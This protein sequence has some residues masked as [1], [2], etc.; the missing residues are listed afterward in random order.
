M[1]EQS[2]LG[3]AIEIEDTLSTEKIWSV[4]LQKI[5]RPQDFLPVTDVITRP[6]D[7]GKGTYREMTTGFNAAN[8]RPEVRV[9][10]NIYALEEVLEVLFVVIN[11]PNEH[12]NAIVTDEKGKRSLTFFLRNATT[13][14]RVNWYVPKAVVHQGI[15][16]VL[17]K[18]RSL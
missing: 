14:E 4:L 7:D 18:A 5:Q 13:K 9:I 3:V 1:A 6:S 11:D 12:V 17:D 16:N 2:G 15:A 10:E 8:G